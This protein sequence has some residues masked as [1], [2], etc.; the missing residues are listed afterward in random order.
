MLCSWVAAQIGP[1]QMRLAD[2]LQVLCGAGMASTGVILCV[3]LGWERVTTHPT[4]LNALAG[5]TG[6]ASFLSLLAAAGD[7]I[8]CADWVRAL[9]VSFIGVPF[10]CFLPL[11]RASC[12]LCATTSGV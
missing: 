2:A 10:V 1:V 6:G 7:A 5:K 9:L 4:L 11:R 12:L 3:V 8:A